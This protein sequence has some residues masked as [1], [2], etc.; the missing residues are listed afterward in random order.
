MTLNATE[1]G[2]IAEKLDQIEEMGVHVTE[3]LFG[4]HRIF[5]GW[6]D[7]TKPFV[8]GISKVSEGK[9]VLREAINPRSGR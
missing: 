4:E 6:K 3:F 1:L 5:L 2:Q 9:A 8:Q 7:G